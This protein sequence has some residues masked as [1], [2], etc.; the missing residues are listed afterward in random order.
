M[1]AHEAKLFRAWCAAD[2][3]IAQTSIHPISG[4]QY[5]GLRDTTE[6]KAGGGVIESTFVL[7]WDTSHANVCDDHKSGS[8]PFLQGAQVAAVTLN[9]GRRLRDS[10]AR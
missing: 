7:E 10:L 1:E 3:V 9:R 8:N 5:P 2:P 6:A 4:F